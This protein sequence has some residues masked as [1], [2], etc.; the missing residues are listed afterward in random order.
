MQRL[1]LKPL[2]MLREHI[3]N[4]LSMYAAGIA[5]AVYWTPN[6]Q[7]FGIDL[8]QVVIF[9]VNLLSFIL[10]CLGVCIKGICGAAGAWAFQIIIRTLKKLT[11]NVKK[12]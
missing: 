2:K 12:R 11:N 10:S 4:K 8:A 7:L 5:S 3:L 9:N 1:S 6:L